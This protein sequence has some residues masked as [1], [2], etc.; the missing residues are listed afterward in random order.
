MKRTLTE[1]LHLAAGLVGTALVAWA[2]SWGVP[3]LSRT[4]WGV[5]YGAMVIVAFMAVRPL[6]LAWRADQEA[7]N[8]R[9]RTDG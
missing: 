3:Y 8:A 7:R 5:A 2:A 4:I 9:S 1:L 6:R